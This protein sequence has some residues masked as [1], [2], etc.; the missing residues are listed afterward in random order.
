M[1]RWRPL[2]AVTVLARTIAA[3]HP[4]LLVLDDLQWAES[5]TLLLVARL[6]SATVPRTAIA[7]TVRTGEE[8]LDSLALLGDVG[9]ARAVELITLDGLEVEGMADLIE[10]R[11][12]VRPLRALA[13]RLAQDTGGNPFFLGVVLAELDDRA[14]MRGESWEWVT[15]RELDELDVPD[16]ARAVIGRHRANAGDIPARQRCR[17]I[18]GTER[19]AV[20]CPRHRGIDPASPRR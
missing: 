15:D 7:A 19:A 18:G 13:H 3:D 16:D 9:T 8:K 14:M 6:I 20:G 5:T 12:G 1:R 11:S 17:T 4:L 2:E 10:I